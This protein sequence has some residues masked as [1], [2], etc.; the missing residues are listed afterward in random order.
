ML[1]SYTPRYV[2]FTNQPFQKIKNYIRFLD[3][4]CNSLKFWQKLAY[5]KQEL[6]RKFFSKFLQQ[7]QK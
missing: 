2:T 1:N 3:I 6:C 5:N 4:S 7:M